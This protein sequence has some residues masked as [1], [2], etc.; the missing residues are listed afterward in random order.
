MYGCMYK[1]MADLNSI[2]VVFFG[3][4]NYQ[5]YVWNETN[6][7]SHSIIPYEQ[8]IVFGAFYCD[9]AFVPT[10]NSIR[11]ASLSLRTKICCIFISRTNICSL[12]LHWS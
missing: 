2:P 12:S 4:R 1:A 8:K 7:R 9:S 11:E 10:T 5:P 6:F 3:H